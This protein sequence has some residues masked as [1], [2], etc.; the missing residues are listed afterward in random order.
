M[1]LKAG[2]AAQLIFFLLSAGAVVAPVPAA[3]HP[4]FSGTWTLDVS[5]SKFGPIPG[6]S[7]LSDNITQGDTEI[8]IHRDRAG[9]PSEIHIPLDGSQK[10]N[11]LRGVT[12]KT[13][14]HWDNGALVI[15]YTGQRGGSAAK[16]E[17]RWMPADGGKAIRVTRHLSGAQGETDQILIMVRADAAA[18]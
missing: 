8:V 7:S 14:G 1:H 18:H 4:D 17:E 3:D 16:V 15:D 2:R 5:K 12:M 9:K 10:D 6:P 13:E 11:I